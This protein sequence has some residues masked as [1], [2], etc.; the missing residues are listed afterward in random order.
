MLYQTFRQKLLDLPR[1]GGLG[2]LRSVVA[3]RG[4]LRGCL[5]FFFFFKLWLEP[6]SSAFSYCFSFPLVSWK[7]APTT[8]SPDAKLVAIS[9]SSLVVCGP[10]RPNSWMSSLQMVHARNAPMMLASVRLGSLVHCR[11][12]HRMYSQ[13]VSSGFWRHLLRSQELPGQT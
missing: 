6:P 2:F 10:L 8:S 13:R 9:K 3:T 12:K 5:A 1:G 7:I 4:S 11:E